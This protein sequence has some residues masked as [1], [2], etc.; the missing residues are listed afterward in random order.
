MQKFKNWLITKL[1]AKDKLVC[2]P[3]GWQRE[4]V[5]LA[6]D[7]LKNKGTIAMLITEY[8]QLLKEYYDKCTIKDIQEELT[9][10]GVKFKVSAPKEEL[11]KLAYEE[12][13]MVVEKD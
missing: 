8:N 4:Y 2:V 13:K 7:S 6:G 11:A 10:G 9:E 12:F 5:K 1:T 3:E